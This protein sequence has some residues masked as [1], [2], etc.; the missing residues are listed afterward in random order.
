VQH[1]AWRAEP[2]QPCVP[3]DSWMPA[4]G[5]HHYTVNELAEQWNMSTDFVRRLFARQPGVLLFSSIRPGRRR[6][7]VLRIPAL[8]AQQVYRRSQL[9]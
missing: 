8:V 2:T 4:D 1:P 6:Y 9:R 5:H 3:S 7:R